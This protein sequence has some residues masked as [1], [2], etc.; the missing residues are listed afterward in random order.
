MPKSISCIALASNVSV[1]QSSINVCDLVVSSWSEHGEV[2]VPANISYHALRHDILLGYQTI[3][4]IKLALHNDE[5]TAE[6]TPGEQVRLGERKLRRVCGCHLKEAGSGPGN[7][8]GRSR[9]FDTI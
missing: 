1:N 5:D 9:P 7:W 4:L 2:E 6:R 8:H 3:R